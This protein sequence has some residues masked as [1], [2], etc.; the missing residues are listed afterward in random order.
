[1]TQ[2]T[3]SSF[4]QKSVIAKLTGTDPTLPLVIFGA[5][6]DSTGGSSSARAPGA[7]DDGS[8]TVTLIESFRALV[9]NGF[10]PANSFEWHWYAGEEGGLLGS[11]AVAANYAD[12]G[13]SVRAFVQ[14]D[15]TGARVRARTP[16]SMLTL[17]G[18]AYSPPDETQAITFITDRTNAALTTYLRSLV[19]EYN[20]VGSAT[21]QCGYACSDHASW[22]SNGYP[23]AFP[24]ETALGSDNPNTHSSADTSA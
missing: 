14:F 20:E 10:A 7:D 13:K 23:S 24:F 17:V 3:H 5:H 21:S 12:A 16:A 6:L 19:A 1:M 22:T 18:A 11:S 2:F 8:G 4:K 9:Q 15:M